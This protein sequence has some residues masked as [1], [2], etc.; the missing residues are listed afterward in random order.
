MSRKLKSLPFVLVFVLVTTLLSVTVAVTLGRIKIQDSRTY[1]AEFSDVSGLEEGSDVRAVGVVVGT[2]EDMDLDAG[3]GKVAVTFSVPSDLP[4]TTASE[5]RIRW[6]NLTGDRYIDLTAGKGRGERLTEDAIIPVAR[7]RPAL[8][9]D[10]LFNGFK[11]LMRG[12]SPKDVNEL[13]ESLVAVSQGQSGAVESLLTHVGSFTNKLADRD[14]LIGSVVTNLTNVLATVDEHKKEFDR[15][16]VGLSDLMHGLAKDRRKIG[17]SLRAI[18]TMTKETSEL[19]TVMRP[20]LHGALRQVGR[21][22]KVVNRNSDYVNDMLGKYPDVIARLGRGGA[23]GSWFNFYLCALRVR[24][25][26]GENPVY[27]PFL[28]SEEPRCQP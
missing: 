28:M 12:L 22:S 4:L 25:V 9:L 24:L 19:L 20:E 14:E 11:P 23:Y 16:V 18:S 6:A 26:G 13:T 5:A 8:D 1:V 7:T 15:I 17:G 27:T 21:V 2:V 10:T 3:M